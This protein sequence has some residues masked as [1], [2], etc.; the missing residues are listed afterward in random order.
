MTPV[1]PS[2]LAIALLA[3]PPAGPEALT[4]ARS[5]ALAIEANAHLL[6]GRFAEAIVGFKASS[7]IAWRRSNDC[8]LGAAY[9]GRGSPHRAWFFLERCRRRWSEADPPGGPAR[10]FP[11]KV[12]RALTQ[13]EAGALA[14]GHQR[15]EL[16]SVPSGARLIVSAF[17]ENEPLIAPTTLYVPR[18]DLTIHATHTDHRTTSTTVAIGDDPPA[19]VTI[20]LALD[21]RSP[22]GRLRALRDASDLEPARARAAWEALFVDAPDVGGIEDRLTA[23]GLLV[24]LGQHQAAVVEVEALLIEP[25]ASRWSSADVAEARLWLAAIHRDTG[26]AVEAIDQARQALDLARASA[27]PALVSTADAMIAELRGTA[28]VSVALDCDDVAAMAWLADTDRA[29]RC[30]ERAEDQPRA[31][32]GTV[33]VGDRHVPFTGEVGGANSAI[34]RVGPAPGPGSWPWLLGVGAALSGG[35]ALGLNLSIREVDS[36]LGATT[37]REAYDD[38][39]TRRTR[40]VAGYYSA[41]VGAAALA[42]AA[43]AWWLVSDDTPRVEVLVDQTVAGARWSGRF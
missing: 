37:D 5:K 22:I 4:E 28:L 11:T 43:L 6:S 12:A 31:L 35:A 27:A 10:A 7:A 29:L 23:A 15:I 39:R 25:G 3:G 17:A 20:T 21:P 9:L 18:G 24:V 33:Q 30:G 40:L 42:T 38:L 41:Q 2:V 13:L 1:L 8:N 34:I 26:D 32:S 14:T 19:P 36:R 16:R